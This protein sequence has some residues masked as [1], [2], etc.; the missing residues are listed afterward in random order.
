MCICC[1]K[2]KF[3]GWA[4]LLYNY[5]LKVTSSFLYTIIHTVMARY[6]TSVCLM[7]VFDAFENSIRYRLERFERSFETLNSDSCGEEPMLS[8]CVSEIERKSFS[9]LK[10]GSH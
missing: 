3:K 4:R 9:E 7:I 6:H 10:I 8:L 5:G 2:T 1:E